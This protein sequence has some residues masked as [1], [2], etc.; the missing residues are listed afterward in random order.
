MIFVNEIKNEITYRPIGFIK[1]PF[2]T[3]E[4]MPIQSSFTQAKGIIFLRKE[5]HNALK[6][7]EDFS[8]V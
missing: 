5:F 4:G 8:R 2:D 7:L 1:T 6:G 3:S